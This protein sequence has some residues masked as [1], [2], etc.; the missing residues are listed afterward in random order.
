MADALITF[1]A[2]LAGL[3]FLLAMYRF[4]RG[5]RTFDRVVAFD[6]MTIVSITGIV[7]GAV[8]EER[9]VYLDVALV[10]ALMSFLGVIVV[11]R[12]LERGL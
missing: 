12:Y 11:A 4:V 6:V 1:A 3:A 8:V 9:V 7:L 5:P 2:V 10:Y